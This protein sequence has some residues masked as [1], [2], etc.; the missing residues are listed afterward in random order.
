MWFPIPDTHKN[1]KETLHL[2]AVYQEWSEHL[3]REHAMMQTEGW[4]RSKEY[5][6]E[7]RRHAGLK[8]KLD[9]ALFEY[10][11]VTGG[12][13]P[14]LLQPEEENAISSSFDPEEA[15]Q[16]SL[17]LS[18]TMGYLVNRLAW[19]DPSLAQRIIR[20]SD[21]DAQRFRAFCE[22]AMIDPRTL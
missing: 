10:D 15:P 8:D 12:P 1:L 13:P 7:N 16:L 3:D 20:N 4:Q 17:L 5:W 14:I 18:K 21:G 22:S 11:Q 19:K 9:E 2:L 6:E